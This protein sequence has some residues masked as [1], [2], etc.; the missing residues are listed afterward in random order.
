[1]NPQPK[2]LPTV[3]DKTA[4]KREAKRTERDIYQ[5]I[6]DR[7]HRMCRCCGTKSDLEHH[8]RVSRGAGGRTTTDNCLTLCRLCHRLAQ[9]YRIFIE[10]E[11]CDLRLTF[12][13]SN[14]VVAHV[15]TARRMPITPQVRV[16][17]LERD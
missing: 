9:T 12:A 5:Q 10:G 8:H 14:I 4:K 11:S 6:D 13:M 3:I 17:K 7:D 16:E 1:M 15:F 2:P